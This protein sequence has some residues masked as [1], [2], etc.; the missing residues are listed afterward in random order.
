MG[1]TQSV[2]S[3]NPR[4][5]IAPSSRSEP[6][7]RTL[8]VGLGVSQRLRWIW[9]SATGFRV[10][11]APMSVQRGIAVCTAHVVIE[12]RRLVYGNTV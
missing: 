11:A 8:L 10:S 6:D 9:P 1:T 7:E 3:E 4:C 12:P 2:K 5:P